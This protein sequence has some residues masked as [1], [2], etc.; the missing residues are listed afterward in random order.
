MAIQG[1]ELKYK[2]LCQA[3]GV[4][5]KSSNA[6]T[7]QLNDLDMYCRLERLYAPT[8]YIVQEVYDETLLSALNGNNKYQAIFEAALYRE[9]IANGDSPLYLSNMEMLELFEEV[10]ENFRIACNK[11][12]MLQ[13]GDDY[14]CFADMGQVAYK[15]LKQWTKRRIEIMETRGIISTARGYRLYADVDGYII[16]NNVPIDSEEEKIC[17]E[18]Y[19]RAVVEIMPPDWHGE[20]VGLDKWQKFEERIK[21]LVINKF[22]GEFYD[23]KPITIIYPPRKQY[24]IEVLNK[25]YSDRPELA[26][27][28]NESCRKILETT[29][30]DKYS[31]VDR[32]RLVNIS[33]KQ[34]PELKLKNMIN[35]KESK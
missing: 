35:K 14:A 1:K 29:Q 11:E 24:L 21:Q 4:P 12:M 9:L 17:Q 13:L 33:I 2:Q 32:K 20:W 30:L 23:M 34:S 26:A 18:I 10:N 27:I 3:L 15:I 22:N 5:I 19:H 7:A 6:K 16:I 28:N 8:R 25:L 31:D